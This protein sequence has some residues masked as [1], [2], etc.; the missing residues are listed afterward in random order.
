MI[1]TILILERDMRYTK[2]IIDSRPN[3]TTQRP[4]Q[5]SI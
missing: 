1:V 2:I 3:E 4:I 5:I